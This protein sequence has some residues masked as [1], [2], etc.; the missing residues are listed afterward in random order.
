MTLEQVLKPDIQEL[1]A[2][3]DFASLRQA[4][5][6][7]TPQELA[8]L[9]DALEPSEDVIVFRLLSRD[10]AADTFEYLST[11]TQ[12]ALVSALAQEKDRLVNLLNDLSPDDRTSLFEELPGPVT[13][14]LLNMLSPEER[15]V[16]VMLLGYPED[17][18]GRLM[19]TDYVALR[20]EWSVQQALDHIRKNGKDSET[21]DVV[22]VVDGAGRL[23]DDLRVRELLLADPSARIADLMDERFVSLRAGDDQEEAVTEFQE[24]DRVALPVTDSRGVLIGI[25][26]VD[27]VLDV[28]QEEATED[29]HKLGGTEALDAPYMETPLTSLVQKR[30]KWLVVLFLGEMLTTTA[31]GYFEHAI[32]SAVVLAIFVPLIISSGGNSGSQAATLIIRALAVEELTL[33]DWWRVMRRE[34]MSGVLLGGTLGVIGVARV[35]AGELAFGSFGPHWP[36]IA[37]TVGLSLLGVVL[38]GTLSGAMLPF[39]LQKLGADPATSSAPLVATMVDV[40]G[41]LLYFTVA[42]TLLSGALL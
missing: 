15:R 24:H 38:W 30:A 10:L 13:Q 42:V 23:L 5:A 27:D 21:F 25:V 33:R 34:V 26:T 31:M 16:A 12:M 20:P 35:V 9:I 40:V 6:D 4:L 32:S 28:A 37:L 2:C 7:W 41:V 39:M 3:R 18:I 14:R 1:I 29:I 11:D 19:T 22:Y 36:L 8:D 17:S